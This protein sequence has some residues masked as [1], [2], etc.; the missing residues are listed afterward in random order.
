MIVAILQ[1]S[2]VL[3]VALCAARLF[4]R[5]SAATRHAIVAAGLVGSL[6]IPFLPNPMPAQTRS[7]NQTI[8]V[9]RVATQIAFQTAAEP[10]DDV[11]SNAPVWIWLA[12]AATMAAILIAGIARI[13]WLVHRSTPP[14]DARHAAACGAIGHQIGLTRRVRLLQNDGAVLGTWGVVQPK[15]LLPRDAGE[16][17]D[18]RIRAVLTH[19]LAHIQRFDWPLQVVA[20]LAR[21][22]YWFNPL[23]WAAGAWLRSESEHA[24]D[25]AVLNSGF[26]PKDYATHLL[27]LARSSR[28]SDR[29]WSVVLA[30]SRPPNL[31]RRFIAMLNPSLNRRS[32]QTL[33]V[34]AIVV[35][36]IGLMLPVATLRARPALPPLPAVMATPL[37]A[38]PAAIPKAELPKP[39]LAKSARRQGRA[40]GSLAGV[41][42]DASG[43]VIPGVRITVA[44]I[45]QTQNGTAETAVGTMASDAAGR[46]S[47]PALTPGQ[48][49]LKA[50]LPGFATF[51]K[52]PIEV[53]RGD[54]TQQKIS[55]SV[56][57][58]VQRVEV[59]VT[60]RPRPAV[61][62]AGPQ[63]IRVGGNVQA[64]RLISQ[65]RP[66]YP[67]NAR[68]AGIEGTVHLRGII[69]TEGNFILLRVVNSNNADL[70]NAAREAVSQ[71]QYRPVLLNNEPIEVETEIDVDFKLV[72]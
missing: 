7:M 13:G 64:A 38:P 43:A 55:M 25:D 19:E 69:G 23:F 17:S 56:G 50:E 72:E 8:S 1:S 6:I 39:P 46:F 44:T 41:V 49:S 24:C 20:E 22:V 9:P 29:G 65:V 66:V 18:E 40:D 62:P 14:T 60:G 52:S 15:I 70:A 12:G 32:I 61:A 59:S 16:W 67:Q 71:W 58:I 27:D 11:P 34:V 33:T 3:S 42:A 45:E 5:Q 10:P 2:I 37:P 21:A 63:R 51:R 30:M 35:A 26:D 28:D 68:D 57:G 47:F 4:R 53:T 54:T 48:Y 36:V 31:E